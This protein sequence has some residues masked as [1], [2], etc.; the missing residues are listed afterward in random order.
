MSGRRTLVAVAVGGVAVAAVT[1][2]HP[3]P[4]PAG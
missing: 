1:G 3:L 4:T 2:L